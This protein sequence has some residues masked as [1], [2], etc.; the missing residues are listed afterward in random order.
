[1]SKYALLYKKSVD[2][3]LR[4]L[5]QHA[6]IAIIEKILLLENN[7]FPEG[8]TKLRGSNN[9]YR[10]RYTDYRL[11]YQVQNKKLV[12]MVI[13]VAHRKEVYRAL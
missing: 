6:R 4:K 10:I 13:K 12:I 9:L 2:K 1:M 7:P 8:H 3:D 11:V 5:P